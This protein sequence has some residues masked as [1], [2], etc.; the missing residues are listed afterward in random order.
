MSGTSKET[1]A[2]RADLDHPILCI[3][4]KYVVD[5]FY[6]QAFVSDKQTAAFGGSN[7]EASKHAKASAINF[8]CYYRV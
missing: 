4:R 8:L 1:G 7:D 5:P 3:Q 6:I 2:T